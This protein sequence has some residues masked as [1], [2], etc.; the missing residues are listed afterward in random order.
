M[1]LLLVAPSFAPHFEGGTE[2]VVRAQARELAARGHD[3]LVVAGTDRP[4]APGGEE[5]LAHEVDGL[6]VVLL[7]RRAD[8]PYD[9]ELLRPRL[10]AHAL[11]LARGRDLV[12]VHHW[13]S[14]GVDLVRALAAERPVAVTLHD[15]F[16]TCPRF[17]RVPAVAGLACPP[18]GAL[19]PCLACIEPDLP[20]ESAR[21]RSAWR[22]ALD[23]RAAAFE[24]EVRAAALL[25]APSASHARAL[26]E[27]LGLAPGAVRAL[28]H[29]LCAELA[30]PAPAP[31]WDGGRPLVVLHAGH[32]A[33]AKGTLELVRALAELPA[34][35]AVLRLAGSEVEPGFD[36][37]LRAAAGGLALDDR[38]PYAP[39]DLPRLA[40]GA[41]L[42]A[43]PSRVAESYGLVVDEALA[44]GLPVWVSDR[45]APRERVGAAGRVLPAENP[46]AWAC[47]FRALLDNPR[48]LERERAAVPP[49]LP[50]ARD[51]ALALERLYATLLRP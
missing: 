4:L 36:A 25:L 10:L 1:R 3:V 34:G 29:G 26:E 5:R 27:L 38:G 32:R 19:D 8:E 37:E 48:L 44:L 18:R 46:A 20:P 7:P 12:H 11:D 28:P 15:L 40:A 9:V 17:F 6:P 24:A 33:R 23:R 2:R 31:A 13:S 42:A 22:A 16:A 39:E 50:R 41:D 43:F 30:R 45:G 35:S 21:P 51:A 47:A 49:A 14:F